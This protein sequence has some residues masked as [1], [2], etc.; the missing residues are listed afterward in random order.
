MALPPAGPGFSHR[1]TDFYY[2]P[3][4]PPSCFNCRRHGHIAQGT[5]LFL[6]AFVYLI[7]WINVLCLDMRC[8]LFYSRIFSLG[9][10][11]YQFGRSGMGFPKNTRYSVCDGVLDQPFRTYLFLYL[12]TSPFFLPLGT[13]LSCT[14]IGILADFG[15]SVDDGDFHI[16]SSVVEFQIRPTF[17]QYWL[18]GLKSLSRNGEAHRHSKSLRHISHRLWRNNSDCWKGEVPDLQV[19][20]CPVAVS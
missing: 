17:F 16:V 7:C 6:F 9:H 13:W 19:K 3:R 1:S 2:A 10:F 5:K 14:A 20:A 11:P 8:V 12:F 15:F 18:R 4:P